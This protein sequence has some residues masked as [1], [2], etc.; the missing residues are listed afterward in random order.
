MKRIA[1]AII[2]AIGIVSLIVMMLWIGN[3]G[4]ANMRRADEA[5]AWWRFSGQT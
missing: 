1:N 5:A 2:V 4:A 3:F